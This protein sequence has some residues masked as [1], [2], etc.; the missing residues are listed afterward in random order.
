MSEKV[1]V[2][3]EVEEALIHAQGIQKEP[4]N[5]IEFHCSSTDWTGVCKPLNYIKLDVLIR[6]LYIGYEVEETPK[7]R[8]VRIYNTPNIAMYNP[9][10]YKAGV[11]D[12]LNALNMKIEGVNA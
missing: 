8:V 11:I 12:A 5:I 7:E 3:R 4:P 1:K 9:N 6:A 2:S 10:S